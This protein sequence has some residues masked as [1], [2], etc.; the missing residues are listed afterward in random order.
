MC[1]R[2]LIIFFTILVIHLNVN[3]KL[4]TAK[5]DIKL[6]VVEKF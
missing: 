3:A 1:Y 2:I 6:L 5:K 4:Q